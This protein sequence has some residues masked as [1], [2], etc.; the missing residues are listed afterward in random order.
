MSEALKIHVSSENPIK[1]RAAAYAFARVGLHLETMGY[2]VESGVAAQPKTIQETY[3][4]ANNRHTKLQRLIGEKAGYLVT[5]ESGIVRP[6]PGAPW[7]GCEVV[8]IQRG[9]GGTPM[10]GIDLGVEYPQQMIDRVPSVYPDLGALVQEEHGFTEKDP[11]L[12]L[13]KGRITRAS[14][15]E[16]AMFKVL[17]QMDL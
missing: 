6:F 4:G 1:L 2:D 16:Q 9:P 5:S 12:F 8:L 13:T 14:L 7:K 11:P 3:E 10:M 17:A 15:I